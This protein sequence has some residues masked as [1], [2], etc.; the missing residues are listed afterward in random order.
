MKIDTA[1]SPTRVSVR[2]RIR[3]WWTSRFEDVSSIE[4]WTVSPFLIFKS[5][6]NQPVKVCIIG[7]SGKLDKHMVQHALDRGHRPLPDAFEHSR[8]P[9]RGAL[10]FNPLGNW[11][12]DLRSNA[13]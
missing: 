7:A 9:R 3:E 13:H 10:R 5:W 12:S 2:P 11:V 1:L 8:T 6:K 4:N